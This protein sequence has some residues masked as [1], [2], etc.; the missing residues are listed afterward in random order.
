[1]PERAGGKGA[2]PLSG[3]LTSAASRVSRAPLAGSGGPCALVA[4]AGLGKARCLEQPDRSAIL[5]L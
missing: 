4:A 3:A 2:F 5:P 1:M